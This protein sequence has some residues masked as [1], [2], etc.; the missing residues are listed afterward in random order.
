MALSPRA[1][2]S[3]SGG[4]SP[5]VRWGTERPPTLVLSS[6]AV[7]SPAGGSL[8]VLAALTAAL[9][10]YLVLVVAAA[11]ISVAPTTTCGN[12]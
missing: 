11:R 1:C 10:S 7:P 5:E 6:L 4:P 9:R 8:L 2:T 3:T 12:Q